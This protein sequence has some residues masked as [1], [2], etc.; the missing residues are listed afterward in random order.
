MIGWPW[1]SLLLNPGYACC[2]SCVNATQARLTGRD[3]N[4]TANP[5][6]GY[7]SQNGLLPSAPF[8]FDGVTNPASVISE[9]QT[10]GN[11]A[12]RPLIIL[13]PGHVQH[14]INVVNQDGQVYFIDSQIG[15]VITLQPN[16]SVRF[17]NAP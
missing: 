2:V 12:A 10:A 8:G 15:K 11:G 16:I 13:Q 6:A 7:S 17:G 3:P 9:M 5:S 1:V 4:A 14:V